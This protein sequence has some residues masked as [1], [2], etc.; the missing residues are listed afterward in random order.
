MSLPN[1]TRLNRFAARSTDGFEPTANSIDIRGIRDGQTVYIE[2]LFIEGAVTAPKGI[3]DLTINGQSFLD[4]DDEDLIKAF[5]SELTKKKQRSLSFSKLLKMEPGPNTLL[6]RLTDTAGTVTEKTLTVT[7]KEP[8]VQQIGSRLSMTIYPFRDIKNSAA[9][10]SEYI[11]TFLSHA[12]VNQKRFSVLER[13]QLNKVIDEQQLNQEAVFDQQTAVRLGRLM[14][15]ETI[16]V[17]DII[18]TEESVEIVARMVDTETSLILAEKD[19]Y[20]EGA[21]RKG[22]REILDGLALKFSHQFPLQEGKVLRRKSKKALINLG[23]VHNICRGMRFLA[24]QEGEPVIDPDTGENLGTETEILGLLSARD[25][26]AK[27]S[28]MTIVKEFEGQ[29]IKE[30]V[31]VITK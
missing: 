14:A 24:F 6:I 10:L 21:V 23:K 29:K 28:D 1:A 30:K 13:D 15:S 17:G 7:R 18:A 25:I 3:R 16:L 27:F 26:K 2:S 4:V 11:Q 5:L 12:F 9:T 20:W 22:F 8:L 31:K 19:V